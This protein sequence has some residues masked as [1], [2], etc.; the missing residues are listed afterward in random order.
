MVT[1]AARLAWCR[2]EARSESRSRGVEKWGGG[3]LASPEVSIF[4][5]AGELTTSTPRLLDSPFVR[6]G[7]TMPGVVGGR[8]PPRSA[9]DRS[10]P[11]PPKKGWLEER[12]GLH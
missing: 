5:R 12:L 10:P 4:L 1:S 9:I 8:I 3:P 7:A 11:A 2:C 6:L